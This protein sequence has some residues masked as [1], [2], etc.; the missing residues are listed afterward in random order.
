M[1]A[2][3]GMLEVKSIARGITAADQMLKAGNVQLLQALPVCPGKYIIMV[4]GDVAAVESAVRAGV[5]KA[6]E[7]AI[8]SFILPNVHKAVFP[9]LS[10]T[11]AIEKPRSIGIIE[12]YSVA[13]AIVAAD[14][15]VKAASVDLLEIRLARGLGGKSFILLSGEVSAVQS[16]V[17]ASVSKLKEEGFYAGSEFI[18]A[19]HKDLLATLM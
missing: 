10:G 3:V 8:D 1:S 14:T 9:A 19:P 5:A 11:T 16:S 12:T 6:E 17:R 18:A 4:G 15:A 2:A 7:L 13:S